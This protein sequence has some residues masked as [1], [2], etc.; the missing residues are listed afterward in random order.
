MHWHPKKA[1]EID[2]RKIRSNEVRR[3]GRVEVGEGVDGNTDVY[4]PII[5][6]IRFRLTYLEILTWESLI[7][8]SFSTDT[9]YLS[10]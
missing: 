5:M 8:Y 10:C 6:V 9:G 7:G 4:K 2:G 1:K 3:R